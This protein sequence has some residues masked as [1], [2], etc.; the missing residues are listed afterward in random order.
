MIFGKGADLS[1]GT[2]TSADPDD[3]SALSCSFID[4]ESTYL[5]PDGEIHRLNANVVEE[6]RLEIVT[7]EFL[8]EHNLVYIEGFLDAVVTDT[9]LDTTI[10]VSD[11]KFGHNFQIP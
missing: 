6:I 8:N 9:M 10:I 5:L 3:L 2:F 7:L 11:I 4:F 1:V